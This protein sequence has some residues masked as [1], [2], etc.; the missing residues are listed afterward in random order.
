M[1][2]IANLVRHETLKLN[3]TSFTVHKTV[4]NNLSCCYPNFTTRI[5]LSCTADDRVV[6][7]AIFQVTTLPDQPPS[8][9]GTIRF[10]HVTINNGSAFDDVTDSGVFTAPTEGFYW[11]HTSVIDSTSFNY[12]LFYQGVWAEQ[13]RLLPVDIGN[14]RRLAHQSGPN[15][16]STEVLIRLK[17]LETV[18]VATAPANAPTHWL[19]TITWLGFRLDAT[20]A[21]PVVAFSVIAK[22]RSFHAEGA[23]FEE[24][25]ED[26]TSGTLHLTGEE[27]T[28]TVATTTSSSSSVAMETN[29]S[30]DVTIETS[31]NSSWSDISSHSD[32]G[33]ASRISY[34][35]FEVP[36]TGT[37]YFTLQVPQRT[38]ANG[39]K[40]TDHVTSFD[41]YPCVNGM[42]ITSLHVTDMSATTSSRSLM[43][44]LIQGQR[45]H[46]KI[47]S[48]NSHGKEDSDVTM[49]W[50]GFLYQSAPAS[51]S[52]A[53]SHHEV[54]ND[55]AVK[56]KVAWS[57]TEEYGYEGHLIMPAMINVDSAHCWHDNVDSSN[58][59]SAG[60]VR[61][62]TSGMYYVQLATYRRLNGV[63]SLIVKLSVNNDVIAL[64]M[65]VSGDSVEEGGNI[66]WVT[67]SDA[68]LL[69]LNTGDIL[70]LSHEGPTLED[71]KTTFS[72]LR[73]SD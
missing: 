34:S 40:A 50:A 17:R 52:A 10:G 11:F 49:T 72:G 25:L 26:T 37:Y 73:L 4:T 53:G 62:P 68:R 23:I 35:Y 2:I 21:T 58:N 63:P 7:N 14:V 69:Q 38:P 29:S 27:E 18:F 28:T 39:Q 44:D 8:A 1:E 71:I 41:V 12:T 42:S 9:N 56:A 48:Y 55:P 66:I 13:E 70:R 6:N 15:T 47:H 19:S 5:F 46:L 45:V 65:P 36:V 32:S 31:V 20:M 22:Q 43:W 16:L 67:G 60:Y 54:V 61:V 59:S 51:A 30:S 64:S 33:S 24:I 3:S 57:V